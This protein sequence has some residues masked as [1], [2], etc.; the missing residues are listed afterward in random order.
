MKITEPKLIRKQ[1]ESQM[2]NASARKFSNE[3]QQIHYF[4]SAQKQPEKIKRYEIFENTT[5]PRRAAT[6]ILS[7][8]EAQNGRLDT[9][10]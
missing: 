3:S 2:S 1:H 4:G 10:G 6:P 7:I 8:K 5:S 9:C